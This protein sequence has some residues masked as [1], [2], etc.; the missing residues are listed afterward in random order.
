[1]GNCSALKTGR[2]MMEDA[3][4][5]KASTAVGRALRAAVRTTMK[6]YEKKLPAAEAR[7]LHKDFMGA[8]AKAQAVAQNAR[9]QKAERLERHFSQREAELAQQSEDK[10]AQGRKRK[11][12]RPS[13]RQ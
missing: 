8:V 1:L 11:R 9:Q 12:A 5:A 10:P 3:I 13:R 6:A 7:A 2:Y 4:A